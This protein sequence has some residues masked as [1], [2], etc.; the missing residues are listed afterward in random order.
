MISATID[1][2]TSDEFTQTAPIEIGEEVLGAHALQ[3]ML[4]P[5]YVESISQI[6]DAASSLS[7]LGIPFIRSR[8]Y[9]PCAKDEDFRRHLLSGLK[10]LRSAAD[11]FGLYVVSEAVS[12]EDVEVLDRYCDVFEVAPERSIDLDLLNELGKA[13]KPILFNRHPFM[14][15]DQFLVCVEH[16]R[17]GGCSRLILAEHGGTSLGAPSGGSFDLSS[18]LALRRETECPVFLNCSRF[19]GGPKY[20]EQIVISAVAA[21]AHGIIG[22]LLSAHSYT[23]SSSALAPTQVRGLQQ[24]AEAVRFTLNAIV[25]QRYQEPGSSEVA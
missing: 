7:A 2:S 14:S 12:A 9:W 1:I 19:S 8:A 21:G 13:D 5:V 17:R 16:L 15:L 3:W 10:V 4:G 11:Q 6:L 20:I 23:Y 25:Q 18:I 24:R 22:D